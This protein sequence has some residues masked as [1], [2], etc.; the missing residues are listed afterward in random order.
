[1]A[2]KEH[3]PDLRFGEQEGFAEGG[4]ITYSFDY[5]TA[6]ESIY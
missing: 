3:R 6:D 5:K 4:F 2:N 1:M